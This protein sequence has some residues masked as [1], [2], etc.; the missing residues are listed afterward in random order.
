[1]NYIFVSAIYEEFSF[2]L[3]EAVSS[4]ALI[5]AWKI[6]EKRGF[7]FFSSQNLPT[8]ISLPSLLWI[9]NEQTNDDKFY[10]ISLK[11]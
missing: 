11:Q 3:D 4:L 5:K 9:Y 2:A 8:R 1:M 7:A 6:I 10:N